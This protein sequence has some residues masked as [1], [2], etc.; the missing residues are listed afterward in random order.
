MNEIA[1]LSG[2]GLRGRRRA[3]LLAT[4]AVLLLAAIGITAGLAVSRQGAPLL[5]AV[6]TDADVAHLVISGEPAAIERVASDPEVLAWSGPF[7][8]VG[9]VELIL[10]D[11]SVPMQLTVLES[12]DIEVNRP[13][14]RSGEWATGADEIV[15]DRSVG[16]DLGIG[17]GD[18]IVLRSS[19]VDHELVVVGTAVSLTD[20]FYPQCDPGRAWIGPATF[21]RFRDSDDVYAQG[22]L[23]FQDPA[24]ADPFVQRQ[25]A[26]GVAGIG[27][28]E[29]WLDTRDDFLALDRIFGSFV[30][31]FGVFVLAV[32]AV[33]I[34]G[35]TA[36]RVVAQRRQIGLLGAI[37]CTPRQITL[38][39][40]V[41]NV[42][43][44]LVAAVVGWFL[45]GFLVPS[46]QLG[47]GLTL[48]PQDPSW[49][50]G[51]LVVC[52]VTIS[53][54]LVLATVVPA[55]SAARRP[56]TD[57]LRDAPRERT[58]WMNRHSSGV[59]SHL[60][61]L[62][63]REAASR[64]LRTAL[65]SVA[66]AVAV[67]GTLVSVG[68][69]GGVEAVAADPAVAG[70]PWDVALVPGDVSPE[71][72][73]DALAATSGVE[74]WYSEV[75][76][77]STLDEGAFLSVAT[78]GDPADAGFVIADGRPMRATD[79]AIAGYGFLE[80]FG[81][82][83]GDQVAVL[84][85]TTPITVRIVGQYRVTE[86]SGEVLR[87]RLEH[88][89]AAEPDVVPDVYRIVVG[90]AADASAVG[91]ALVGRLG[92]QARTEILD[93]GTDDM[94]P[95]LVALRLVALVL[96]V[97]A[98]TNLLSTL[99]T[100][101]REA[102]GRVGVQLALGFTPRQLVAE[103]A[104]AGAAT[105]LLAVATGLPLGLWVFRLLADLV[106]SGMGVGPGWMP[107][108]SAL[109]VTVLGIAAVVV[110]GALGA[111]AVALTASRPAADLV[112]GE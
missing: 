43:I 68:M 7:T 90:D 11:E 82:A 33:V 5:D 64:P 21:S 104:V 56:V 67:V 3:G 66:I 78:G 27:G 30:S 83:V 34:A 13:A 51:G 50:V 112:R 98:A 32:A 25:A 81:L 40:L 99:L 94:A 23:R 6:A 109:S 48:G 54:I 17:I 35:S 85:G 42:L 79:E 37:G 84:V 87:Y 65:S 8:T 88:L 101:T 26:A 103:G 86:D 9:G 61:L 53:S 1:L 36:I 19:G 52:V 96:L 95:L 2:I 74:R 14:R 20:C 63:V 47:I 29:S 73:E 107:W 44:G 45:G 28:T 70:T 12:P 91:A 49:S 58:S 77:R 111:C 39:L 24:Q 97:M 60:S 80:R 15:L 62:G 71:Q 4:L 46:L 31:A 55:V 57:V 59:P 22:W 89:E 69:I 100:S 72:V 76:R 38:G 18:T 108:P 106:S 41:E 16:A 93:T 75:A 102:A 10:T 105:G 92:P 110:S